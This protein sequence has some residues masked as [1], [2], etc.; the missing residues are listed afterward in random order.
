MESVDIMSI[1]VKV[2]EPT[3]ESWSAGARMAVEELEKRIEELERENGSLKSQL[4]RATCPVRLPG[5]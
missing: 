2:G 5:E 1:R 4:K 3:W